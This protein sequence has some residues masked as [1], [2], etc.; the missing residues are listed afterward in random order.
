MREISLE[1]LVVMLK[2]KKVL[3]KML[4]TMQNG[5]SGRWRVG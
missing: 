1:V 5:R 3:Y 2:K 4:R